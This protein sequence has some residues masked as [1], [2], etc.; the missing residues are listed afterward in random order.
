MC[1]L[2]AVVDLS[3]CECSVF[4]SCKKKCLFAFSYWL[5]L[6]PIL[7]VLVSTFYGCRAGLLWVIFRETWEPGD[8]NLPFFSV[9]IHFI[10]A[11]WFSS[12]FFFWSWDFRFSVQHRE[13]RHCLEFLHKNILKNTKDTRC[14]RININKTRHYCSKN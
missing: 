6:F 11:L 2:K 3:F 12:T 14:S 1:S 7:L 5:N 13:Q 9:I 10:S 4:S 8:V